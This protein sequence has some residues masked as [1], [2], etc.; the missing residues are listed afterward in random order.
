[1]MSLVR[2]RLASVFVLGLVGFVTSFGAHIV[3]VNLPVYAKQVGVGV[4]MIG[5]LIAIYDFAEI[6]AKPLFGALADRQGMKRTMLVGIALFTVAS[7]LYLWVDPRLLL[8]VRFLQG[9]GAAALSAVSLA[10]VGLYYHEQRGRAFGIYNTIKGAGYVV[11][12]A[13]GGWIVLKSDFAAIFIAAAAVGVL[14]FLASLSLPDANRG[15]KGGIDEDDDRF[16]FRALRTVFK[17][18]QLWKWYA[19][20]VVNMFFVSILFGFLPVRIYALGYNPL[21]TGLLLS[22]VAISYLLIQP[23]AGWLADKGGSALT[24]RIGLA[25]G[26]GGIIIVPFVRGI[27]LVLV[28]V[29][30]GA[31]VGMVWTNTDQ[32]VSKLAKEGRMGATMGMAGSFK[33]LGD[34]VGPVVI[35]VLSQAL[36]LAAGFA[37]CG[38]AGLLSLGLVWK[39]EIKAE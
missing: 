37:I 32:V 9:V 39:E 38:V 30:A 26:A 14:A 22:V 29:L 35:G 20:I 23:L 28:S 2:E 3:A 18:A 1:M 13:V 21:V 5:L 33:E 19:V 12:P 31:G 4:A 7:L 16:S 10:L 17:E 6:V 34:M 8:L 25:L 27:P 11:S 24:I 15:G 36:G